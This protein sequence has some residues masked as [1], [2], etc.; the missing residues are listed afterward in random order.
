[1]QDIVCILNNLK[2]NLSN[3]IN[4]ELEVDDNNLL[5]SSILIHKIL[6]DKINNNNF[7]N[8]TLLINNEIYF[9]GDINSIQIENDLY[10]LQFITQN[11]IQNNNYEENGLIEKFKLNNPSLF[12]RRN[13]YDNSKIIDNIEQNILK[14]SIKITID[15]SLPISELDLLISASWNKLCSGYCDLTNKINN[16]LKNGLISTLTPNKLIKSWP[17]L[18]DRLITSSVINNSA[19]KIGQEVCNNIG[20]LKTKYFITHSK[21]EKYNS[22]IIKLNNNKQIDL[23]EVFFKCKLSVGWEYSQFVTENLHCKIINNIVKNNNKQVLNI[24]LHN[25]QEYIED[26]YASSF[27]TSNKKISQSSMPAHITNQSINIPK[28]TN[29]SYRVNSNINT[30]TNI[31]ECYTADYVENS[32]TTIGN[33]LFNI[34]L[35]EVKQFIIN[36]MQN[37]VITFK[38]P[39]SNDLKINKLVKISNYILYIKKI[40]LSFIQN[41]NIATITCVGSEYN[42]AFT[43]SV[44]QNIVIDNTKDNN[45]VI[46]VLENIDIVN[47]SD[48]QLRKISKIDDCKKIND[49]LNENPTKL[50]ITLKP[51]KTE[52]NKIEK[53]DIGSINLWNNTA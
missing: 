4:I 10:K 27:V 50:I 30:N 49:I 1:M 11:N 34:I 48:V 35:C 52:H 43:N 13:S 25:V 33:K 29:S 7:I 21:L 37:V 23:E 40:E 16:K 5:K 8:C 46:D 53:I 32:K 39:F 17:K 45:D 6:Y 51:I 31:S 22:N 47:T 36:S 26:I 15:K 41:N 12:Q 44:L 24:N 38:I 42:N 9:N 3:M 28:N 14:D 2:F 19:N 20:I 18:F